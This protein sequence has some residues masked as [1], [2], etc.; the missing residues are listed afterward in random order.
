MALVVRIDTW[1]R[2]GYFADLK[3]PPVRR[4]RLHVRRLAPP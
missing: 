1:E 3:A 4:L 2:I